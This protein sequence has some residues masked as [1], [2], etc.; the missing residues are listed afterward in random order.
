MLPVS[1]TADQ[2]AKTKTIKFAPS[3]IMSTYLVAM[4]VGTAPSFSFFNFTSFIHYL[5]LLLFCLFG[6]NGYVQVS[7][8]T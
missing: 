4:V 8:T 1:E 5:F 6:A 7:S 3:P 2:Q